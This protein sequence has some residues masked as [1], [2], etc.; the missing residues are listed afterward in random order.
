MVA[1][2]PKGGFFFVTSGTIDL[3]QFVGMREFFNV[4]MAIN[5][6]ERLVD[7]VVKSLLVNDRAIIRMAGKA[8]LI[9]ELNRGRESSRCLGTG[10]HQE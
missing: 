1:V 5:A 9:G 6:I 7:R 4:F 8:I 2:K 10:I 3:L